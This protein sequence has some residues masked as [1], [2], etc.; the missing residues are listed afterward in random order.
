MS[1]RLVTEV[2]AENNIVDVDKNIFGYIKNHSLSAIIFELGMPAINEVFLIAEND[3]GVRTGNF[4]MVKI[5]STLSLSQLIGRHLDYNY[6]IAG[7]KIL[8]SSRS[9]QLA[10][11]KIVK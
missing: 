5:T 1:I 10:K 9:E 11:C 4:S 6:I 2:I 3:T 8:Y 7:F